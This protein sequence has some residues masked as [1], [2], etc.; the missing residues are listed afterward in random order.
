MLPN[1]VTRVGYRP[2]SKGR[3][4]VRA[5]MVVRNEA[6]RLPS[7]L[8]HH[9]S[10]GV[11]RFFVLDNGSTD[12]TLDFVANEPDTYVFK[13]GGSYADSHYGL[14]WLNALLDE[15]GNGHWSL[16]V[17]ADEQIIYPHYETLS[18][19]LLCRYLDIAGAQALA[20]LLLDL[21]SDRPIAEAVHNPTTPLIDTCRYFDA[22]PY[23]AQRIPQCPYFEI[24]GGV[25]ERIFNTIFADFHP[26]TLSKV[27]LVRWRKG[28]RFI[29]ST[30]TLTPV[31]MSGMIACLLHFK[32]LSDFHQRVQT[33]VTR[34][35]H[36]AGAR[37]YRA[38]QELL[39]RTGTIS[40]HNENSVRFAS[41]AQ[42]VALGLMR[43]EPAF[44]KSVQLTQATPQSAARTG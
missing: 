35:E 42:L 1:G 29:S 3:D 39:Q 16:V 26:P 15:F 33:E 40:F 8:Q 44:E 43:S 6:L 4:E 14:T 23:R 18:L 11:Q 22:G 41:S 31:K 24:H 21:Y 30:H 36:F 34:N 10:L 7:T 2:I 12:G 13:T 32:F 27:P 28:M 19:P 9:R 5:F 20:C 38:Y 25:R 17:D 37:E